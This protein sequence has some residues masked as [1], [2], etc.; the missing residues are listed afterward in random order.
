M[1][2]LSQAVHRRHVVRV[3]EDVGALRRA[4]AALTAGRPGARAGEVELVATELAT[5]IVGHTPAGGYVLYRPLAQGIELL[6]VDSGP[7]LRRSG[8]PRQPPVRGAGLGVGLAGVERMAST[9]DVYSGEGAGTVVLARLGER[10]GAPRGPFRWGG[11]SVPKVGEEQSGDAWAVT[12]AG[13][14]LVVLIVDGLGHGAH[15]HLAAQAALGVFREGSPADLADYAGRAH[16]AMRATRGGVLGVC[17]IDPGEECL[18][19]VGVGNV[20]GRVVVAGAGRS[21]LS[22]EGTVGTQAAA[23]RLRPVR[24]AWAPGATLLLASDGLRSQWDPRAYA[25]L[26]EHDP[27]VVAATL[28]RDHARTTDDVTVLVVRDARTSG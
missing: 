23:P 21:L 15:A 11:V 12:A 8:G 14:S 7:G 28:H 17:A 2:A 20:A 1:E 18:T 5:N 4:V 6:A 9:F 24:Y 10:R 25:G 16:E 27:A 22:Q 19:F 13:G 26:L 3:D